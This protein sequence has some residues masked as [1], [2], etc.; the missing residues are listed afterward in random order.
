[1]RNC[2]SGPLAPCGAIAGQA[3]NSS[4]STACSWQRRGGST[5]TT[6]VASRQRAWPRERSTGSPPSTIA[7]FPPQAAQGP[8]A[9]A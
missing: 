7:P 1:M 5:S 8:A 3:T 2:C 9:G 6:S 4:P